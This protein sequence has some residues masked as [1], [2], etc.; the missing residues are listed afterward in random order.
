MLTTS[1]SRFT[2]T[3][4]LPYFSQHH[5]GN[6]TQPSCSRASIPLQRMLI[7][8]LIGGAIIFASFLLRM[9]QAS[10]TF[11]LF[12]TTLKS[13]T[14]VSFLQQIEDAFSSLPAF[15]DSPSFYS[16][17]VFSP[18]PAVPDSVVYHPAFQHTNPG[19]A[20]SG[21]ISSESAVREQEPFSPLNG[22]ERPVS[23]SATYFNLFL[24]LAPPCAALT[25]YLT[26]VSRL[27][28]SRERRTQEDSRRVFPFQTLTSV[29][30]LPHS[31]I[32]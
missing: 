16:D 2:P 11:S 1:Q 12:L 30:G 10:S 19:S 3:P 8:H 15:T 5:Y 23:T 17:I 20:E 4:R 21:D 18:G 6:I 29:S 13:V 26:Y 31:R 22:G 24:F 7:A 28:H 32:R 27:G 14:P 25:L 9:P